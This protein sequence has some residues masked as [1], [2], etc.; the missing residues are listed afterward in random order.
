MATEPK[1]ESRREQPYLGIRSSVPME[2]IAGFIDES[3]PELF[4]Y[5]RTLGVEAAGPPF[6]RY[7]VIDMDRLLDIETGVPVATSMP[8]AGR[9]A[10]G[11]V[12]SG[13]YVTLVHL[14]PYEG[15]IDANEVLQRWAAE[16]GLAFAMSETPD[17]DRFESRLEVYLTDPQ[18]EP[19]VGKW[20]TE[21]A[22]LLDD[23]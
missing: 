4:A 18:A 16:Q 23:D 6:L 19:D 7:H 8:G 20:A 11:L 1:I 15:L 14:G 3:Y 2:G 10:A 17:G 13:R 21:V 5:L 12:P 9:I 22:Y